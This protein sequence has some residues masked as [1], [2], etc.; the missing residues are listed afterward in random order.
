ML[1]PIYCG[2]VLD[3]FKAAG[4]EAGAYT[5]LLQMLAFAYLVTFVIH[6]FLAPKF[7]QIKV[8]KA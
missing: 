3:Q 6:H 8:E 7:E 1:F 4:N 5:H 2:R